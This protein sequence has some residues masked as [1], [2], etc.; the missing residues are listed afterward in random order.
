MIEV[1]SLKGIVNPKWTI[2]IINNYHAIISHPYVVHR[3]YLELR[4]NRY[5]NEDVR[6]RLDVFSVV[7]SWVFVYWNIFLQ[8]YL[9]RMIQKHIK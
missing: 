1:E 8:C 2:I 3:P 4:H 7:L 5:E 9:S 6:D